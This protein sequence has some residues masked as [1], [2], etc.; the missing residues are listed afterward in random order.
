LRQATDLTTMKSHLLIT[1]CYMLKLCLCVF[2][3][4]T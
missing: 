3:K 2:I 1:N 4:L